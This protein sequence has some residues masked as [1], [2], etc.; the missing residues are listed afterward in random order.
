[1]DPCVNSGQKACM[2][3]THPEQ[4]LNIAFDLNE[5]KTSLHLWK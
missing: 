1:M 5:S 3:A 2:L 4:F